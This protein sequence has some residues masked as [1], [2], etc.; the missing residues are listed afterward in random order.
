MKKWTLILMVLAMMAVPALA[1]GFPLPAGTEMMRI[2]KAVCAE[3]EAPESCQERQ[4]AYQLMGKLQSVQ[5]DDLNMHLVIDAAEEQMEANLQGSY[6]YQLITANVGLGANIDSHWETGNITDATGTQTLNN[7]EIIAIGDQLYLSQDGGETWQTEAADQTT[8]IGLGMFLGLGGPLG[9]SLDLYA[10]PGI[11]TVT[12]EPDV[13]YDGQMMHVQ[14]LAVD[15]EKLLASPDAAL[16]LLEDGFAVGGD[17]MGMS[18]EDLG[19][20]PQ[21]FAMVLP[22]MLPV[23]EGTTFTTTIY[24]GA[25]DGY[26]HYVADDFVLAMDASAF[27]PSQSAMGMTYQMSG[28]LTAHNQPVTIT[29]PSNATEG[30][31]GLFGNS[32]L[33]GSS[34]VLPDS[35]ATP[36]AGGI[37]DALFGSS[38]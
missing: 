18:M 9:A 34:G 5:V 36:G 27:D 38:K 11:F 8:L 1:C 4:D 25:D 30:S 26:I 22:M 24:I 2:S 37:G 20:T 19:M 28:Y 29:A 31:D 7:Y 10:D 23:L 16:G 13:E 15:L 14:T 3:G 17:L 35:T 33:F 21:Q 12:L 32:G 6:E